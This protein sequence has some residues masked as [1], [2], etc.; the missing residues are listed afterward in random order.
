M[1]HRERDVYSMKVNTLYFVLGSSSALL[2]GTCSYS[3]YFLEAPQLC[4]LLYLKGLLPIAIGRAML[5]LLCM[6]SLSC[7]VV[8]MWFYKWCGFTLVG[9]AIFTTGLMWVLCCLLHTLLLTV[10]CMR[11]IH[12]TLHYNIIIGEFPPN[13]HKN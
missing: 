3:L 12:I 2:K 5:T 1:Q 9:T 11:F 4:T 8:L 13:V 10:G 6:Q 7:K